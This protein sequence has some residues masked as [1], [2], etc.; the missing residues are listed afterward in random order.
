MIEA[1][2]VQSKASPHRELESKWPAW[3]F[4]LGM[5]VV[6]ALVCLGIAEVMLRLLLPGTT[7]AVMFRG[8]HYV[9][10]AGYETYDPNTVSRGGN[11]A[12][13][14]YEVSIDEMGLRNPPQSLARAD[15]MVLGDSLI[16]GMN[17]P[18]EHTVVGE[19]RGAGIASYNAGVDGAST[20][21]EVH[22][23]RDHLGIWRGHIVVVAFY[24]GND[25]HD[26]Y[27]DELVPEPSTAAARRPV[28]GRMGEG[29]RAVCK[30]LFTCNWSYHQVYLGLIKGELRDPMKSYA[31]AQMEMLAKGRSAASDIA[32]AHTRQA[33]TELARIAALRG[34]KVLVVGVPSEAQV[35]QRLREVEGFEIDSRVGDY[36]AALIRDRGLDFDRPDRLAA[37]LASEAGFPYVSLLPIFRAHEEEKLFYQIDLHWTA[38]GQKLAAETLL[39]LLQS[40]LNTPSSIIH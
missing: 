40:M 32:V 12:G 26:N 37:S 18:V 6:T 8:T 1:S 13:E 17:T 28:R 16:A 3:V 7:L 5:L 24:L 36:G 30:A 2:L 27:G 34:F 25:F 10:Y 33:F 29:M 23:L 19:L 15:V 21:N 14:S 31:L 20:F 11:E 22:L 39:P 35:L 4:R 38:A 9:R